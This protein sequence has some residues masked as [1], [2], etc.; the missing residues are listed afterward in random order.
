[1]IYQTYN[2]YVLS[3]FR[4]LEQDLRNRGAIK[5]KHAMHLIRLLLAGITALRAG[6]IPLDVG[7]NR[8]ALLEIRAGVRPWSDVDAWRKRL[9]AD[10]DAALRET[11]L[12]ERPDYALA[13]GLLLQARRFAAG[14]REA[15][16]S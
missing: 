5:W 3:Q 14:P 15:S 6:T 13:N 12:P 16:A 7:A 4:K 10:F 8:A 2:G 1:M 11:K 9:H